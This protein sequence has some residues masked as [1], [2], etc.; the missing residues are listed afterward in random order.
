MPLRPGAVVGERV[1]QGDAGGGR[2]RGERVA[3]RADGR[4]GIVLADAVLGGAGH[5]LQF[6]AVGQ[7]HIAPIG[8]RKNLEQR[9]QDSPENFVDFQRRADVAD[10]VEHGFEL[11]LG[12]DFAPQ[13]RA[14]QHRKPADERR[15]DVLSPIGRRLGGEH[16]RLDLRLRLV[17]RRPC[18]AKTHQ[19]LIDLQMLAAAQPRRP[20]DPHAVDE[21]AV[22]ALEIFDEVAFGI[23]D[24][25][26][27]PPRDRQPRQH[28]IALR[29]APDQRLIGCERIA[30][31]RIRS[32]EDFKRS[33]RWDR[34]HREFARSRQAVAG[35]TGIAAPARRRCAPS[36]AFPVS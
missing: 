3:L 24:D 8:L 6:T 1:E 32:F 19:K 18:L 26:S 12:I 35:K 28:D 10:D 22:E 13:R 11:D 20:H 25:P 27:V 2:F 7:E 30:F 33:F 36:R 29:F 17:G 5:R 23:A 9:I 31:P 21:G 34:G 4:R 15:T 16:L 14:G